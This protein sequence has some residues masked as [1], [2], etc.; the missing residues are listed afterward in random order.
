MAGRTGR[1][2]P[3]SL[4]VASPD[5]AESFFAGRFPRCVTLHHASSLPD[6]RH[7]L[8]T[9]TWPPGP[10]FLDLIGHSTRGHHLLRLGRTPIDMLDRHVAAFFTT[11][12][13]DGVLDRHNV[14]AVRLLGCQTAVTDPARRTLRMLSRTLRLPTYGT[15]VPL[16]KTHSDAGGLSPHFA[17]VLAPG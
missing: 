13:A 15:L 9:A 1:L 14:V 3:P 4:N 10:V 8:T 2:T 12:A 5:C 7:V 6:L 11:L 17:H 16:L